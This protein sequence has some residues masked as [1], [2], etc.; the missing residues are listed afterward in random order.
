MLSPPQFQGQPA[1]TL[2]MLDA[3]PEYDD[4]LGAIEVSM[5]TGALPPS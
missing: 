5:T 1:R 2:L 3:L 4:Y